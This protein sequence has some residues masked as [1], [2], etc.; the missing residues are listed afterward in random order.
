MFIAPGP[1]PHRLRDERG[2]TLVLFTLFLVVLLGAA[3]LTVDYGM[4]LLSRRGY[5]NVS[6][7]AALAGAAQ[8]T[9]PRSDPCT[10][11]KTKAGCAR[12]AA[13]LSVREQLGL[14]ALDATAQSLTNTPEGDPYQE[15]GYRIWVD[16]PPTAA[17]ARYG[18]S[19]SG[20]GAILVHVERDNASYF[21][22]V[23][24][25]G[26]QTVSAWA[27]A[28]LFPNRFAILGLCPKSDKTVDCPDAQDITLAGT[29]TS[30]RVID[31]DVGSNWGFTVTSG[32][33]PGLVLPGDSQAYFID[34]DKCSSSTWLCPP[35]ITGGI[36]D[37]GWPPVAKPALR[38]A[39]PVAD[40]AYP[41][42]SWID[43]ATAVPNRTFYGDSTGDPVDPTA[44]T[45]SC[46]AGST[47]L[48][49][50]SYDRIY[51]KKGCV[52]LD[53]TYGLT[54]GQQPG[55]FRIRDQLYI[56]S[57]AFV[58]GDGVSIFFDA[59]ARP[60][61]VGLG[62]GIVIN[63]GNI[64]AGQQ[65]GAWT[66]SGVATWTRSLTPTYDA[67]ADG[68]G[69]AFYVRPKATG[70]T[71]IFNMSGGSGLAFR[72]ALYGPKDAIGVGGNGSQASAGQ[73]IGYTIK[74]NGTT[75]LTQIYEGPADERPYLLEP[76]LGQ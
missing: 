3:A 47:V 66:T 64:T 6:D 43:D 5:Q 68:I 2:Q 37:G 74:Y 1:V 58:I 19:Y 31:G 55:I 14:S 25:S 23:L 11:G 76:T 12:E 72:G 40:P 21:G 44:T 51:L 27:T 4:W 38:L 20:D 53:P 8:L 9:R 41:A 15:A 24:G 22:R 46:A 26:D 29:N 75:T 67:S 28:G 30:V 65:R 61:S 49:P 36:Q 18:G 60:L 63:N 39:V 42:P 57:G 56:G 73:I 10:T 59:A 69:M 48:G 71:S 45:V 70:L 7:A 50:G 34:Y 52:I 17:G 32:A 33:G 62:G 16:T 54:A 35:S 13:W